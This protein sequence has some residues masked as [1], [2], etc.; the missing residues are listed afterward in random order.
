M[1]RRHT[2]F[3]VPRAAPT[4]LEPPRRERAREAAA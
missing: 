2:F 3:M 1:A 4:W